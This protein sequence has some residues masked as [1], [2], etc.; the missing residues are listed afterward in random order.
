MSIHIK[1]ILM[2]VFVLLLVA[3]LY[4]QDIG[5]GIAQVQSKSW[6]DTISGTASNIYSTLGG[7]LSSGSSTAGHYLSK[8][9]PSQWLNSAGQLVSSATQK[10]QDAFGYIARLAGRSP[11]LAGSALKTAQE[12]LTSLQKITSD[13]L[14]TVLQANEQL[15]AKGGVSPAYQRAAAIAL[16]GAES[17]AAAYGLYQA[18][19]LINSALA[20]AKA[21]A[22]TTAT[23]NAVVQEVEKQVSNAVE[24]VA[25]HAPKSLLASIKDKLGSLFYYGYRI[26]SLNRFVQSLWSS[27]MQ[28]DGKSDQEKQPG[29][30]V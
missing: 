29:E 3:Q 20:A 30:I 18:I 7:W 6:S 12:Q 1:N 5:P 8:I 11:E 25:T 14:E 2:P 10:G 17:A 4:G 22:L 24:Q 13:L 23:N 26:S 16:L 28:A 15:A 19:G 9:S 27:V 21:G